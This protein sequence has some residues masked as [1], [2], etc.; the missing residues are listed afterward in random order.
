MLPKVTNVWAPFGG[1]AK[2]VEEGINDEY[3]PQWVQA[4]GYNT[5]Y[6]GKLWN[7]HSVENYNAPYAGGFNESDSLLDPHT[8]QYRNATVTRNG[9][10][11]VN[12]AG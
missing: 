8:Y 3:L 7:H 11:P 6:S 1:Y 4:A 12:Y 2:I 9:A 5:Y 10:P